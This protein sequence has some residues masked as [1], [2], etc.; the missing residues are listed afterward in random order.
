MRTIA[1]VPENYQQ[2]LLR[3]KKR[4]RHKKYCCFINGRLISKKGKEINFKAPA[5]H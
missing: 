5:R 2:G 3:R 1:W 4:R